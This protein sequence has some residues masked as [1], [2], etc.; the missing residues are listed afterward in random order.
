MFV[1]NIDPDKSF[2]R[3]FVGFYVRCLDDYVNRN[4]ELNDN[5]TSGLCKFVY[6]R[7]LIQNKY[8]F[9]D[10]YSFWFNYL[11][12]HDN[13]YIARTCNHLEKSKYNGITKNRVNTAR[14]LVRELT[15]L[16]KETQ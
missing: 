12:Y 8:N 2:S 10:P 9:G 3:E 1:S 6:D 7:I 11:L 4:F 15:K 16:L 5:I 13:K 14:I